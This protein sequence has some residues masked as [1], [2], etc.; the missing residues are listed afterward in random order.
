MSDLISRNEVLTYLNNLHYA[1]AGKRGISAWRIIG[2][3]KKVIYEMPSAEPKKGKWIEIEPP[4]IYLCPFCKIASS[5]KN[6]C[7]NCGAD[8]REET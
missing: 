5:K 6:F 2:D 8:M 1:V 3:A 4:N 7:A